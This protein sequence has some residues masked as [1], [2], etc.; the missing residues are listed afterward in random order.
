MLKHTPKRL[1]LALAAATALLAAFP[2]ASASAATTHDV[3]TIDK[4][5]GPNVAVGAILKGSLKAGT[6]ATFF[7]PGTTIGIT[8]SVVK[9]TSKVTKNPAKPGTASEP[10][11]SQSFSKCTTNI[12]GTT[13]VRSITVLGLPYTVTASDSKGFPLTVTK[14]HGVLKTAVIINTVLGPVT[15]TYSAVKIVGH[16]SNAGSLNAYKN[17]VFT[18][19][20][21][22][23]ACLASGS[24][25]AT[26]GPV[27]DSSVKG[28]PHIFIN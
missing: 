24:F 15:C 20:A 25:S 7:A 28:S 4:V 23:A 10:L 8:C 5:G 27:V 1:L 2:M 21:G 26:F 12:P 11:L 13:G 18:K 17:Q 14:P 22:P 6:K 3:L 9:I 16:A 19:S